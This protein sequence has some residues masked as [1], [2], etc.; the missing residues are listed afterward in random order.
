ML[1]AFTAK[2]EGFEYGGSNIELSGKYNI[3]LAQREVAV[4]GGSGVFHDAQGHALI[5]TISHTVDETVL[6]FIVTLTYE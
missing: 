5:E 2:L 4:V 3:A 6:K 1:L